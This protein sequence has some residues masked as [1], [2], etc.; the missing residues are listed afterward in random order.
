MA[1]ELTNPDGFPIT[2]PMG[3]ANLVQNT[4]TK[5]T[6]AQGGS[7]F[8]VPT[9]Y[10]FHAL[11]LHV[12]CNAAINAGTAAFYVSDNNTSIA[13]GPTVTLDANTQ[14]ASGVQRPAT[15]PIAAGHIVGVK[16]APDANYAPNTGDIDAV[17]V[18]LLR[19]V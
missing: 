17:V 4:A 1:N 18:G 5:L 13:N 12:E 2:I 10:A 15:A 19:A 6:F 7:G 16:A 14:T 11:A 8:K 3:V 9:G